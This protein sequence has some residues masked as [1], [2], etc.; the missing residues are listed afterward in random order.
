MTPTRVTKRRLVTSFQKLSSDI[1]TAVQEQYPLGYT[2]AMMRIDKPNG[3]FFYAVPFET[4]EITYLVKIDVKID[5]SEKLEKELF[6]ADITEAE[7]AIKDEDAVEIEGAED[8][9]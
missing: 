5:D 2:D 1:Q 6:S 8:D 7:G 3:D 9:M 4:E